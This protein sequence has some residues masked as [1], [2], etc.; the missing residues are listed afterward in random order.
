MSKEYNIQVFVLYAAS[1]GIPQI[2]NRVFIIGHKKDLVLPKLKMEFNCPQLGFGITRKYWDSRCFTPNI[3]D[4][5]KKEWDSMKIGDNSKKI[6]QLSKPKI[7]KPSQTITHSMA[8]GCAGV[9]HPTQKRMLNE[10]EVRVLSTFPED[11]DFLDVNSIS[12]MGRSVLP[13]M[14]ANISNQIYLQWLSKVK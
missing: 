14:M 5:Y 4:S 6:F 1:M 12:V 2:R 7:N 13:V 10:Y 11:Y 9:V 3:C 8:K